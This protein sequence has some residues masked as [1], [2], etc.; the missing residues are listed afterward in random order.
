MDT[1]SPWQVS[2]INALSFGRDVFSIDFQDR[3]PECVGAKILHLL[4]ELETAKSSNPYSKWVIISQLHKSVDL[5]E[6]E[7]NRCG[8]QSTRIKGTMSLYKQADSLASFFCEPDMDILLLPFEC[9]RP[10]RNLTA[11]QC[12]FFLDPAS[13]FKMEKQT[14]MP[15]LCW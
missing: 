4:S 13:D 5:V 6:D 7:L 10:D 15:V 3:A 11:S 1:A 2:G 14:T 12:C 9:C 8:F